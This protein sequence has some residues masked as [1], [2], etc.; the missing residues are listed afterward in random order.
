MCWPLVCNVTHIDFC[1]MSGFEPRKLPKKQAHYQ[2]C[3]P[4]PFLMVLGQRGS[5]NTNGSSQDNNN[6]KNK[7]IQIFV[8]TGLPG[9]RLCH[10]ENKRRSTW[11]VVIKYLNKN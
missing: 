11:H 6:N 7:N 2:L 3:H 8:W 10:G 5:R 4:F 1:E 9:K